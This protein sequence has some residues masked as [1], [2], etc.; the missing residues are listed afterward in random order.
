MKNK[1]LVELL[2]KHYEKKCPEV[3]DFF[4]IFSKLSCEYFT[5][6]EICFDEDIEI[7]Y[8]KMDIKETISLVRKFLNSV[9]KKYLEI[10]NNCLNDGT[11]DMFL[12][13]DDLVKRPK[14]PIITPKP[15]ANINI[16][17]NYTIQDGTVIVHEF[18][19]YLNDTEEYNVIREIFTEMIS[20]Y[21]EF[22]YYQ[23]LIQKGYNEEIFYKNIYE[24][25]DNSLYCTY[26]LCA[27]ASI[28]DVYHNT[29]DIT[30]ENIEF[31]EEKRNFYELKMEDIIKYYN[32][33]NFDE[34]II[35]F[36]DDIGYVIGTLLTFFALKQPKIYDIKMK[37]LN[38]NINNLSFDEV[39]NVLN[40]KMDDYNI[41]IKE[42]IEYLE[43]AQGEIYEQNNMYSG[44]NR[45][46][47]N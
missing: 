37:Y 24:R 39:L 47:K 29:G 20:I 3:L 12:P 21:F 19:H 15:Q 46:R 6:G 25:T 9:D 44:A 1:E 34:N 7:E 36:H 18:F 35:E 16:P 10:F 31:L 22:R 28:L 8:E 14:D 5:M 32:E 4:Y 41:W 40:T 26:N 30:S 23:F 38:E 11:F 27:T 17:I 45:S 42:N 33:E 13:E 43:K 2:L